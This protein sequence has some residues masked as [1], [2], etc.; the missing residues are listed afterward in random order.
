MTVFRFRVWIAG[1]G[2]AA[3]DSDYPHPAGPSFER[4]LWS[5]SATS[6]SVSFIEVVLQNEMSGRRARGSGGDITKVCD[7]VSPSVLR[8]NIQPL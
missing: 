2:S 5:A 6:I 7:A 1:S 8:P 4:T 3:P